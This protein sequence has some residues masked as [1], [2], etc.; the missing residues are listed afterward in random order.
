MGRTS[1]TSRKPPAPDAQLSARQAEATTEGSPA[2]LSI[3]HSTR[4]FDEFFELLRAHGVTCVVDVRTIPRSRRNP[5]FNQETLANALEQRGVRYR[6]MPGLGGLRRPLRDSLNTGW[7]N[8]SFRGY[9]D[10]MQTPQF[11]RSLAEL[12]TAAQ[13]ERLAIMCAEAVPWRCHRSLIADGLL[14]RGILAEHIMTPN[15]RSAHS[16]TPFAQVRGT[17]I[18]Y[19][20]IEPA[21]NETLELKLE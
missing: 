10:Y 16:L 4:S 1:V 5:Q 12:I 9:A 18:T 21:R 15:K 19:P 20:G 13:S 2:I 7:R 6:A 11:K 17:E 14:V 3:G 8:D